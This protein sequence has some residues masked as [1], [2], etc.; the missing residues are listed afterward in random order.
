VCFILG[1]EEFE[2]LKSRNPRLMEVLC[3]RLLQKSRGDSE[4][5]KMVVFDCK[6]YDEEYF[7]LFGPQYEKLGVK[8]EFIKAALDVHT[9]RLAEGS[10]VVSN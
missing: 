2:T 7:G 4:Q 9:C 6:D 8:V 10:K 1:R 5:L 3:I